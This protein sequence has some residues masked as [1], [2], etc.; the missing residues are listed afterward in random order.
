MM[1]V[2]RKYQYQITI[3]LAAVMIFYIFMGLGAGFFHVGTG[4]GDAIAEVNGEEIPL[5]IFYSHYRR[6]LNQVEPGK[7]LD[8]AARQQKRDETIRD[9]VQSVIFAK[10]AERY[11]IQVPD[12]Q[13]AMSLAQ[14][15]AFQEK[16]QFSPRLY[17]QALQSQI[18][19]SPRDFEEEQR[20]SL[21]FYKLRCMIQ[22]AIKVTDKEFQ[23][24]SAFKQASQR[25]GERQK[26]HSGSAAIRTLAGKS[27][28]FL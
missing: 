20:R 3:G 26:A 11:G 9:M 25:A 8:D 16:G 17:M 5:K 22:S 18:G 19:L 14:T 27:D 24:E 12:R 13:V 7:T 23:M 2:L 10:E 21:A 4:P 15:P 6:A 28:V 1:N